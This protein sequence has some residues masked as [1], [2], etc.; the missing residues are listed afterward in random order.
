MANSSNEYKLEN[1]TLKL[2]KAKK[3]KKKS[4]DFPSQEKSKVKMVPPML[5]T[6]PSA[7][8]LDRPIHVYLPLPESDLEAWGR[9]SDHLVLSS[10]QFLR[11]F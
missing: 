9:E 10:L 4:R 11:R 6:V 1:Q 2:V 7:P 3:K 5:V 8:F